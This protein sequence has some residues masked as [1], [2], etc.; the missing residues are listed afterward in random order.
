MH[1]SLQYTGF[2]T[3]DCDDTIVELSKLSIGDSDH[4]VTVLEK[5]HDATSRVASARDYVLRR[6]NQTEVVLFDECYPDTVL[7]NCRKIGEGVYGEVYLWRAR[8]G[9]ARVLK[10]VPIAGHIKVNGEDQK[11]YHEIISEI[12]IAMELSALRAPIAKIEQHFDEGKGVETLDLH[13]VMNASDVFNEVLAVRCVQGR[14]PSRLLDLWELYDETKGSENDTPAVLPAHQNYLVLELSNAGQ[15][16]EGYQFVNAEQAY[17]LFKQV[18]FGLAVAE[19]AFQFEH[20]DL[21]WGNVLISPTDQKYARFVL[22]G[23]NYSVPRRGVAA[24]I[25]DYSLSRVS[26]PLGVTGVG[27]SESA[28]LYNDLAEDDTLFD[29]VGDYQ[30][31]VYRLMRQRLGNIWK[32]FDPYTNILWLHYTVD[33]MITALRYTRANTKVHK[34][35]ISKLKDIKNRILDYGSAAQYVL[36][37]NEL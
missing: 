4:E 25:I 12:V 34:Q 6:C 15:D 31:E 19:E 37:D 17:A 21:H 18:A 29:A 32:N 11:D 30:F 20:R 33:K 16:L 7:K 8:D 10:I 3:D 36:T 35:Y 28:A 13:S 24:T 1:L 23:R 22:R 2:L 26:L 9:R 5:F 27:V 14:Y